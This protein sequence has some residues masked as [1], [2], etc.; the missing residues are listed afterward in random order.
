MSRDNFILDKVKA[1]I[2]HANIG[3]IDI[4]NIQYLSEV[5]LESLPQS[6]AL[7]KEHYNKDE[8]NEIF[9]LIPAIDKLRVMR[10]QKEPKTPHHEINNGIMNAFYDV[11]IE[12]RCEY[13]KLVD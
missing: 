9:S 13:E 4:Y 7:I 2:A 8:I 11:V 10:D 1:I 6:A 12:L 3:N 5:I